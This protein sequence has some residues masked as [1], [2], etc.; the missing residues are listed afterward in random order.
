MNEDFNYYYIDESG[1]LALFDKNGKILDLSINGATKYF[2]LGLVKIKNLEDV[3]NKFF[4]LKEEMRLNPIYKHIPKIEDSL[5]FFH[6]KNDSFAVKVKV[7]ELLANIDISVQIIFRR[8][9]NIQNQ[10]RNIEPKPFFREKDEYHSLISRLL[11]NQLHKKDSKIIFSKR[12]DTFSD[13]SL[14][15]ALEKAGRNFFNKHETAI[16]KYEVFI[17][18]PKN[19]F[20]LQII[21][22]CLWALNRF[23]TKDEDG[24]LLTIKDKIKLVVDMDDKK[25]NGYGEYYA[26]VEKLI[27]SWRLAI[28]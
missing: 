14:K 15:E 28:N 5:N 16:K 23:L 3:Q 26:D 18:K 19:H 9:E 20:G 21:D 25:R 24:Y 12:G 6:A 11:R 10:I 1:D 7:F 13:N 4:E 8:K 17:G 27:D 22:Y 2:Y